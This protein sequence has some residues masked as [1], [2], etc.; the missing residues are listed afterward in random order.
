[1]IKVIYSVD[2]RDAR[3]EPGGWKGCIRD[4]HVHLP[5][6]PNTLHIDLHEFAHVNQLHA[7]YLKDLETYERHALFIE[8]EASAV[9][10]QWVKPKELLHAYRCRLYAFN[11]H[12]RCNYNVSISSVYRNGAAYL[13]RHMRRIERRWQA[14]AE[15]KCN[16]SGPMTL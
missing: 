4:T 2:E 6:S 8:A 12:R 11:E 15:S 7:G 9:A 5:A 13:L 3:V 10:L 14:Y 16:V 1:M